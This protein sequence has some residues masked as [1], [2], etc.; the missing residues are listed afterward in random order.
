[1]DSARALVERLRNA[2]PVRLG[3]AGVGGLVRSARSVVRDIESLRKG[4]QRLDGAVDSG[5]ADLR[6][7]TARVQDARAADYAYARGLLKLPSLQAPDVSPALFGEAVVG[8]VQ[9]VLYGLKVLE[10]YLPPGLDPRRRPGPDRVRQ[11]GVTV[12]FPGRRAYPAFLLEHADLDVELAGRGAAAGRYTA[13]LTGLASAPALYGRPTEVRLRRAGERGPREIRADA[14]LDHRSR[15]IVDSLVVR[16]VD[17][18]LPP[19]RL[20]P[21]GARLLLNRGDVDLELVRRGDSLSGRWLW[22]A[23]GVTW[24]RLTDG[25]MDRR[26][27]VEDL[28]WRTVSRLTEVRIEMRLAGAVN[29]PAIGVSSNVG[30][31]V[32]RSLRATVG[33]E[34]RAAE[35]RVRAEVDRLVDHEVAE[36][37]QGVASLEAGVRADVA[38]RLTEAHRL[39]EELN[40]EL[41]RFLGRLP[42]GL[43]PEV[44]AS[45]PPPLS[46]GP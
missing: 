15:P 5:M 34:V 45:A 44:T 8:W 4:L 12:E 35:R 27:V 17:V 11:A 40:A 18:T 9:P 37:R 23:S 33:E 43:R 39:E 28:L 3:P 22:T 19:L 36:L 1:M 7:L 10:R 13:R 21:L 6:G 16:L 26:N 46:A 24:E 31:A 25:P 29:A 30:D 32:A 42:P 38:A 14:V 20:P 2:E 41:E